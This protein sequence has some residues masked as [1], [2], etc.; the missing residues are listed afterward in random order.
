L[1]ERHVD[2]RWLPRRQTVRTFAQS[3]VMLAFLHEALPIPSGG[4]APFVIASPEPAIEQNDAL[5]QQ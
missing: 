4:I 5:Q 3:P 1:L 2:D